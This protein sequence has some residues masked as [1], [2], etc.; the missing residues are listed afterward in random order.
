METL[1]QDIRYGVRMLLRNPSFS[2]VSVALV[3]VGVGASTAV[4]SI[5]NAFLI[6]PLPY[7]KPDRLSLL[8]QCARSGETSRVSHPNYLDWHNR[9]GASTLWPAV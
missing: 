1:W 2:L 8:Y 6:R 7:E 4:F 3:A 9:P 5:F